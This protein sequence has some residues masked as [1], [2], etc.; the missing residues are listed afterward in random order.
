MY[1]HTQVRQLRFRSGAVGSISGNMSTSNDVSYEGE[2]TLAFG[3]E[4][5]RAAL[6]RS[7]PCAAY[8]RSP[9]ER[10]GRAETATRALPRATIRPDQRSLATPLARS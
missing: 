8:G 5:R 1:D 6:R 3:V 7:Y 2:K 4:L 10:S 9:R